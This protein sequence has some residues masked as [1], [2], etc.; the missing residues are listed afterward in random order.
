MERSCWSWRAKLPGVEVCGK[1]GSAQVVAKARLEK[2]PNAHEMQPHGW[3]ICFAPAEQPTIAM[4]VLVEH[5]RSGAESAVPVARE[6]LARG[7]LRIEHQL[8]YLA[9]TL[10][11]LARSR[12]SIR[13]L[14]RS[15][16]AWTFNSRTSGDIFS[17]L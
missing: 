3:F 17:I 1:T 6:I 8:V 16:Y 14:T 11:E 12:S 5:G 7:A 2:S 13:W 10:T 9:L 4:A 15:Q